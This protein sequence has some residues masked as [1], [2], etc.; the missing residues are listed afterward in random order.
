MLSREKPVVKEFMGKDLVTVYQDVKVSK[1]AAAMESRNIGSVVVLD[2]LGPCGVFTE[3]DLL[4][5]VVGTGKD[6]ESTLLGEVLSPSFPTARVDDDLETS[7]RA[8]V[9]RRSR[10]MV[11]DGSEL[12]GV[13][14]ST[15]IVR[16]L[17]GLDYE[18]SVDGVVS[19]TVTSVLPE[20]PIDVVVR[21][22]SEKRIGSVLV[23]DDGLPADI[24]TERDLLRKVVARKRSLA[25]PVSEYASS[26]LVTS[27]LGTPGR[28][29]AE[30]MTEHGIKRLPLTA[31]ERI[32]GIVTAR[33][34]VEAFADSCRQAAPRID[35]VQW[36]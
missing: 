12:V 32:G 29:V 30:V 28:K 25:D 34:V 13:V 21:L 20:T 4:S 35:W 36:N 8:M 14:T 19:R 27:E 11:F 1:A 15:D 6:P 31:G 3:R 26:P 16:T 18:F 22:M 2:V 9:Q 5:R 23:S 33:D 24:F 17:E 7:A 10:L